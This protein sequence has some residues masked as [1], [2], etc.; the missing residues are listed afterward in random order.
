MITGISGFGFFG[1]KKMAFSWRITFF[2]KIGWNPYFYSVLWVRVFW[3][4]LSKKAIFG[5]PLP[6]QKKKILTDNW[7]AF[8][9]LVFLC[10][11]CLV[12]FWGGF[13]GF[14]VAFF[15][16]GFKGQVRWPE[17]PPHLALNPP[18]RNSRD[19]WELKDPFSEQTPF[20]MTPLV[21][22]QVIFTWIRLNDDPFRI[23]CLCQFRVTSHAKWRCRIRSWKSDRRVQSRNVQNALWGAPTRVVGL[24][25]GI[26]LG[27]HVGVLL[28]GSTARGCWGEEATETH[29]HTHAHTQEEPHTAT[30]ARA[31]THT[32]MQ[33]DR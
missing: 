24:D 16:G 20:V 32:H 2:Q 26:G 5:P 8:L 23:G 21:R 18:Y 10:F 7:K 11:F 25:A 28:L 15:L 3:A 33:T 12:F 1:P 31:H 29:I 6:P 19:C 4:K 13:F 30:R 9:F 14:F 22:S 27:I 17:G